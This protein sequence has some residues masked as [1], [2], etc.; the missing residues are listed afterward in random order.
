MC[1]IC[2]SKYIIERVLRNHILDQHV[3]YRFKREI[4][5]G[6]FVKLIDDGHD[7]KVMEQCP[8]ECYEYKLMRYVDGQPMITYANSAKLD[9]MLVE[10]VQENQIIY[11]ENGTRPYE[12]EYIDSLILARIL[13]IIYDFDFNSDM[14]VVEKLTTG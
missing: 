3:S 5:Q 14:F 4:C 13:E 10:N 9:I 2:K 11:Y 7:Y 8:N 12:R 1:S 6:Q